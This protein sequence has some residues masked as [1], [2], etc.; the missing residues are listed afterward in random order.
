MGGLLNND[1]PSGAGA[2]ALDAAGPSR[3]LAAMGVDIEKA[4]TVFKGWLS[5]LALTVRD[6]EAVYRREIEH[7]GRAVAVLPYD[8]ERRVAIL[9]SQPR[10]AVIWA[11][12]PAELVEAPAGM[13]DGDDAQACARREAME[14]AGLRLG[15]LEPVGSAFSMPGVST[16]RVDL[17]LAPY[18]AADRVAAG[19]GLAEEHE[20]ITVLERPLAELWAAVERRQVEDMKTLALILAL[21][22]RRPELF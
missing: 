4:E 8:A 19:G 18:S 5:V 21:K 10:P 9:V 22:V 2:K 16:E 15:V 11:G 14:E 17:F 7:H 12:G 13:V 6:G 3:P 20:A 1:N